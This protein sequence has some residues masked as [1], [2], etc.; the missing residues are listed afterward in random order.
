LRF[1]DDHGSSFIAEGTNSSGTNLQ[2]FAL[3]VIGQYV[4]TRFVP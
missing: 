4:L 2:I 1:H 3:R